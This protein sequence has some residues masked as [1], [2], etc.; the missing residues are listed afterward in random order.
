MKELYI[1][2]LPNGEVKFDG[3]SKSV[4]QEVAGGHPQSYLR[5]YVLD[6]KGTLIAS[7]QSWESG[8]FSGYSWRQEFNGSE[9]NAILRVLKGE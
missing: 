3:D 8:H 5:S 4:A 7:C 1:V 6:D 9:I 2:T